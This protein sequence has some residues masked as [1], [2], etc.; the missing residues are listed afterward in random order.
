MKKIG[1]ISPGCSK[2]L[3]DTEMM[4]GLMEKAGYEMT[5]DLNEANVIIIN[6]CTFIDAAK[7]ESVQ[8]LLQAT[9]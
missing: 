8:T 4:I 9:E 1:F 3:V 7:D 5:E 2:N 6:T